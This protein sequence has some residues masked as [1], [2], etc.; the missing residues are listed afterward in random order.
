MYSCDLT[1]FDVVRDDPPHLDEFILFA[2][3]DMI[4]RI[5]GSSSDAYLKIVDKFND[6]VVS[7]FVPIS[8][9]RFL[10]LHKQQNSEEAMR[11]FF[12]E[13]YISYTRLV[14]DLRYKMGS[15]LTDERFDAGIR[16]L[17]RKL[18]V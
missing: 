15:L 17:G 8:N 7:A 12:Q 14:S 18:L 1:H 10:L 11:S 4:D 16:E 13:A 2:S 5:K 9:V 6:F 3:L